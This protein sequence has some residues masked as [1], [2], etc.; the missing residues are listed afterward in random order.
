MTILGG[1]GSGGQNEGGNGGGSGASGAG[2]NGGGAGSGAGTGAGTG[3]S[4][5]ASGGSWRD[6]LPED[7]KTDPTLLPIQNVADLAKSYRHAQSLVG[8]KGVIPPSEK[9]SPEEW[10]HFHKQLGMPEID[11][12]EVKPPEGLGLDET[13]LKG[14]RELAHKSGILPRQSQALMDWYA[15]YQTDTL[16]N[17]EKETELTQKAQLAELRKEWGEGYN[18]Q[19]ALAVQ[20]V[21]QFGGEEMQAYLEKTGLGND[22][23]LIKMFAKMGQFLGEDK[24]RG[25]GNSRY[26]KTPSE[27]QNQL[28]DIWRDPKHPARDSKHPGHA[29]AKA[30]M[31]ELYQQLAD[32][33]ATRAS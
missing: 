28:N 22:T 31:E 24:L 19:V 16:S 4:G 20:A 18:K 11:K 6:S 2:S 7:L 13:A 32:E 26:G 25:E 10:A 1:Q 27:I 12:Y 23:R 29:R 17:L 5:G 3:G 21:K 15:K 9:A 33:S 8:K 30:E 14:F